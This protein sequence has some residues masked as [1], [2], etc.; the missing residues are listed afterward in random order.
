MMRKRMYMLMT[1]VCLVLAVGKTE[2]AAT[3][4]SEE[5]PAGQIIEHNEQEVDSFTGE[6]YTE[7]DGTLSEEVMLSENCMYSR[8]TGTFFYWVEGYENMFFESSAADGMITND[9]VILN[10]DSG[11][12]FSVYKD[13]EE[14][15]DVNFLEGLSEEG[16]YVVLVNRKQVIQFSIVG[17]YTTLSEIRMPE[18]FFIDYVLREGNEIEYT[19]AGVS[20]A[21]EGIYEIYYDCPRI[22][23]N[24]SLVTTVDRTPPV[25]ALEAVGENGKAH[26][27]VDISDVEPG[28]SIGILLEGEPIEA[29][30]GKLTQTGNYMVTVYDAAGNF[31]NYQFAIVFYFNIS[32]IVFF[33]LIL[34]VIVG[35]VS[36]IIISRKRLR[37]F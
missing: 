36:Y 32:S 14:I 12:P 5:Q 7:D 13:G 33:L 21:E 10:I 3:E 25:L 23:M 29:P 16:N 26:G 2:A 35:I 1:A 11:I 28:G 22:G 6:V 34:V 30:K 17:E 15:T 4:I 8:T 24:Y 20:L 31:S 9:P 37:V 27:P 19:Q 18:L